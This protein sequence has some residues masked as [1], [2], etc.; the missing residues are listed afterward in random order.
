MIV[1]QFFIA[2]KRTN[3]ANNATHYVKLGKKRRESSSSKCNY[4]IFSRRMI[5]K[6]IIIISVSWCATR[7][8]RESEVCPR[9]PQM[10]K[11]T[12]A[13][14]TPIR[15]LPGDSACLIEINTAAARGSEEIHSRGGGGTGPQGLISRKKQNPKKEKI[16]KPTG[17]LRVRAPIGLENK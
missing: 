13:T 2:C 4:Y 6:A 1:F 12:N 10:E 11:K 5:I 8:A 17:I 7:P 16:L 14:I 3:N 15:L 9:R